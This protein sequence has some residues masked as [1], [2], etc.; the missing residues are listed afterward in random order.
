M[1]LAFE[2]LLYGRSLDFLV[3]GMLVTDSEVKEPLLGL[4]ANEFYL[5]DL[6]H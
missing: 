1:T 5:L 4:S 6:Q 2:Y 3:L